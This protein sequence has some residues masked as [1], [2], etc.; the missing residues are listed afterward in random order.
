MILKRN[1]PKKERIDVQESVVGAKQPK[2]REGASIA[3]VC[4]QDQVH[5]G[6]KFATL[7]VDGVSI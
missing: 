5:I 3:E 2:Q 7:I 4:I 1:V 6:G